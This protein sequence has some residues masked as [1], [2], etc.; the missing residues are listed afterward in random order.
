MSYD[1]WKLSNPIDDGHGTSMVSTCCGASYEEEVA[2]C[3]ECG[4]T[5]IGEVT[6]GDEGWTVCNDCRAIEQGYDYVNICDKCDEAC[7]V[8][9]EYEYDER[10]RE[11]YL[12]MKADG[13]R[14]EN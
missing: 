8:E 1:K 6:S 9:E 13:E 7:E 12:E 11:N 3:A 4:T 2:T 5:D 14:D 10:Q